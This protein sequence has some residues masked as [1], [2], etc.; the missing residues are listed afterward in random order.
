MNTNGIFIEWRY[1]FY[2]CQVLDFYGDGAS[3][4]SDR[5]ANFTAFDF[6]ETAYN[7]DD[8]YSDDI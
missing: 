6:M 2:H 4:S 5:L 1:E 3:A 7:S 8:I